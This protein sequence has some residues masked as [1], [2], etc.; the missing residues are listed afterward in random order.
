M[1]LDTADDL[2]H[3]KQDS[4]DELWTGAAAS[5]G[6]APPTFFA[7]WTCFVWVPTR[8]STSPS[9]GLLSMLLGRRHHR[10]MRHI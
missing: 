6:R 10:W 2:N 3:N 7:S 1:F 4:C 5:Y 8:T 9:P